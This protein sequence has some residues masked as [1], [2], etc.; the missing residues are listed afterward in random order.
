M[1]LV[2][3]IAL[4]L[5]S[6]V[7]SFL[8]LI[9]PDVLAQ[10]NVS[11]NQD[12]ITDFESDITL[13]KNTDLSVTET[14]DVNFPT[15]KHG[16]I[17]VI[18][19]I[20]SSRG[21]TINASFS[22]ISI[23]DAGGN[24]YKYTTSRLAQSQKIQIGD[25]NKTLTGLQTYIIKYR[26]SK[27][28][29]QFSDH[30]EIYWNV[31]GHE[32]DKPILSARVVVTS[33][34]ANIHGVDCF[35]GMV[36]TEEKLCSK[37]SSVNSAQFTSQGDL[38]IGKD[39]TIVVALA[40]PNQLTFPGTL[41]KG[42]SGVIDNIGYLLALIPLMILFVFWY[43][44]GRDE[45]Y[46]G[47]NVYYKPDK[48]KVITNPLFAR[49]HLPLVYSP[50]QGLTPA[51]VGTI[52]DERVDIRDIIAEIVE[53]ARLGFIEIRKFEKKKLLGK[54]DQ[55]A[56]IKKDK[57]VADEEKLNDYQKEILKELFRETAITK[58]VSIASDLFKNDKSKL[59]EA[60]KLMIDKKYVLLS[61]LKNSFYQGL[62]I[63]K[64]KIYDNVTKSGFFY[65]NPETTRI[66]W[67]GISSVI[68]LIGFFLLQL[69]YRNTANFGPFILYFLSMIPGLILAISMP[70][71]TAWG[72]SLFRQ[73]KGLA[74]YLKVGKWRYE[75]EEKNLF[76][77]E[78]IPLAISLGVVDKLAH[79]MAELGV[80]PPSY[81]N[82][83]VA[84]TL[85]N[86]L[87]NFT[88]S[89]S[90]AFVSAPGGKWSGASSWSGGS[91]FGGGG[92]SGG[93]FGGGGG[94]S[95]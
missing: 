61:G 74:Y 94:G 3:K 36:G 39:F 71:K 91:G 67:I 95:W 57:M 84:A 16:I 4:I 21:R 75:I 23:T 90:N 33:N 26:I 73:A 63:I 42:I 18:P 48:E 7:F 77:E 58:S 25:P 20:Y 59:K 66:L 6:A 10:T 52:I 89:T 24:P 85:A 46:A 93:G 82:G 22:I 88:R 30:D 62:S 32:W 15:P 43:L 69:D 68:W 5:I 41:E 56:F 40:K 19:V 92:F 51:Q 78:V 53:L 28:V 37:E 11:N 13:E 65:S 60:D 54:E 79:D 80:Q 12:A 14:I 27:V 34:Y 29:R 47:D 70:R 49:E 2:Q 31:T 45:R 87:S 55:Y 9:T 17:R 76:L 1:K 72:H 64:K 38:G 83:F 86:D 8:F 35:A 81:F 50:I 44:R